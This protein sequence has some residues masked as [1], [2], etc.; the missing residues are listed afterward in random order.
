M[1]SNDISKE[2]RDKI[3]KGWCQN[4]NAQDD[5][6]LTVSVSSPRASSYCLA[7]ALSSSLGK[8]CDRYYDF[9]TEDLIYK[10]LHEK[11]NTSVIKWNDDPK[12]TK[13]QVLALLDSVIEEE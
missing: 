6:G 4:T 7:G 2:M 8:Y 5:L 1:K 12:R 10:K 13:K 3:S 9:S 11:I